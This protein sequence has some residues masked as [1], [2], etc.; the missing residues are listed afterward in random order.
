MT[1]GEASRLPP[2]INLRPARI[3][4]EVRIAIE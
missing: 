4:G 1:T 2:C 3:V